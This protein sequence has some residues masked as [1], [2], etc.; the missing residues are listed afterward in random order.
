MDENIL[1]LIILTTGVTTEEAKAAFDAY[2]KY[3]D[4]AI[5]ARFETDQAIHQEL[6][7]E[8]IDPLSYKQCVL[9]GVR[10]AL[11]FDEVKTPVEEAP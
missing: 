5:A 8:A 6:M 4:R 10:M 9:F 7:A 2:T 1:A 11:D 3:T